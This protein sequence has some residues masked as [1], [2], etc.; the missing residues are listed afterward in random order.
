MSV[1]T[2]ADVENAR[3]T[4]WMLLTTIYAGWGLATWFHREIPLWL[5]LPLGAVLITWHGSFQHEAVHDHFT[6]RRWLNDVIVYPPLMLWLP[7]PIYR[8]THRAHHNVN[9]LTDPKRDPESFYVD[10]TRW[11]HLPAVIRHVLTWHNTLPGRMLLGPFLAIGQ[12]LTSEARALWSGDRRNLDAWL[13]HLPAAGLVVAWLVVV[14]MP[15][16]T[17]VGC[18]VLPGLS[19]TLVRSFAEHKAAHTPLER[20][21]IVEAG[22]F[23]SLLFL[24]NNLHFAHHRRPDLPW[25]ALPAYY[26]QHRQELLNENGGLCYR[27]GY[28]EIA[29]RFLFHPVDLPPHPFL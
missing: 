28:R 6:P 23:F 12:F 7:Y 1:D 22:P 17:Y 21:A 15:L 10:R 3:L 4:S 5:L 26:R 9:I 20:T 2:R 14:D 16:W 24:N 29:R 18:F 19:L 11:P 25:Q 13:W 27:G 8:R